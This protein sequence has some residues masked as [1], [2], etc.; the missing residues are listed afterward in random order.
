MGLQ[1]FFAAILISTLPT[2]LLVAEVVH[3]RD[4]ESRE[5][6]DRGVLFTLAVTPE[7]DVL[8]FVAKGDGKWRLTRIHGW[9][10][11][12]PAE[13]TIDIP[14]WPLKKASA[15]ESEFLSLL[16]AS[17]FVAPDGR[18]AVCVSSGH[19]AL[20]AQR[21]G[22][23]DNIVT[24]VDL[25]TFGVVKTIRTSGFG[26]ENWQAFMNPLG[27]LVLR[28]QTSAPA[29]TEERPPQGPAT[30]GVNGSSASGVPLLPRQLKLVVLTVP[31]LRDQGQ[32]LYSETPRA[33]TWV[34]RKE[35]DAC[36]AILARIA[37]SPVSLREFLE[38]L[39][40][41]NGFPLQREIRSQPCPVTGVSRDHRLEKR[42]CEKF[43]L[44]TWNRDHVTDQLTETILSLE[45]GKQ[46]GT[47]EEATRNSV[48]SRFADQNGHSYLLVMEGGTTLKVYE[49]KP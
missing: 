18:Y 27:R 43:H 49:I 17:L 15:N 22:R 28:A 33:N 24:V 32:C 21:E 30:T 5:P 47:V 31:D 6:T 11:K 19:W 41:A 8:S 38:S 3:V 29:D 13:Q 26:R 14:G 45:T 48:Q 4:Y 25:R 10:E 16:F 23:S 40:D 1:S 39:E 46:V 20:H 35:D 44:S 9:L 34:V 37:S 2:G 36:D 42:S 7:Q 12:K